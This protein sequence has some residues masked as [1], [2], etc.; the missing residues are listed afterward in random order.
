MENDVTILEDE[1]T[2]RDRPLRVGLTTQSLK[3]G[4]NRTIRLDDVVG[5]RIEES[6]ESVD[7]NQV[8]LLVETCERSSPE[9]KRSGRKHSSIRLAISS[10]VTKSHNLQVAKKWD[11]GLKMALQNAEFYADKKKAFLVFINPMSGSGNK[12]SISQYF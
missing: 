10:G 12:R 3:L 5:S 9:K 6:Y 7:S 2:V 8:Y 11:R 4:G 1:F